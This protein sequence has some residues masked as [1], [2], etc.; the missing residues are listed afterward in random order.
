VTGVIP[1]QN[2]TFEV[3]GK[4]CDDMIEGKL[5][6]R[7]F[8]NILFMYSNKYNRSCVENGFFPIYN[9]KEFIITKFSIKKYYPDDVIIIDLN[10]ISENITKEKADEIIYNR[11]VSEIESSLQPEVS[12]S[13]NLFTQC[14]KSIICLMN[15]N[16]VDLQDMSKNLT[17]NVIENCYDSLIK[18][19]FMRNHRWRIWINDILQLHYI[20]KVY[21]NEEIVF[22][23]KYPDINMNGKDLF[24]Y[25]VQ[26]L[27]KK[28]NISKQDL[29]CAELDDYTINNMFS[30]LRQKELS[31]QIFSR[32]MLLMN[33]SYDIEF[34]DKHNNLIFTY[35]QK[36]SNIDNVD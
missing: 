10:N 4:I 9:G 15:I 11:K 13:D 19:A 1:S 30:A 34:Y 5:Y 17:E 12:E 33:L 8:D 35:K 21:Q 36:R 29:H 32:F 7:E 27:L 20:V 28:L 2:N 3:I 31:A 25:I 6:Y 23:G 18:I 14:I 22:N 24:R 16:I 26:T